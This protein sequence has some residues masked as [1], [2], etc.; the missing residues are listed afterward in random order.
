MRPRKEAAASFNQLRWTPGASAHWDSISADKRKN[1]DFYHEKGME[2]LEENLPA[3]ECPVDRRRKGRHHT[4]AGPPASGRPSSRPAGGPLPPPPDHVSIGAAHAGC[5][6][7]TKG[8]LY[9]SE[10]TETRGAP[11]IF[12][13]RPRVDSQYPPQ[14]TCPLSAGPVTLWPC[15]YTPAVPGDNPS[16]EPPGHAK[17]PGIPD[18]TDRRLPCAHLAGATQPLSRRQ[19]TL[20]PLPAGSRA[21]RE[22]PPPLW[23]PPARV[24]G[25]ARPVPR[26]S[27]QVP[28]LGELVPVLG[29]RYTAQAG[30]RSGQS[31]RLAGCSGPGW[32]PHLPLS[33]EGA[34]WGCQREGLWVAFPCSFP[35]TPP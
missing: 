31:P 30:A 9:H 3:E 15:G 10:Q 4:R 5:R 22:A 1:S 2:K 18:C 21:L 20:G 6:P 25:L 16:S 19:P 29:A 32:E 27:E 7:A 17:D 11:G 12:K 33:T 24:W 8:C 28:G 14:E 26:P 34:E 13:R 23:S 35:M